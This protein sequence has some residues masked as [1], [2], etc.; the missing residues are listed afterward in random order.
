MSRRK[1]ASEHT[2]TDDHH[3]VRG[4]DVGKN[5]SQ[6]AGIVT[7]GAWLLIGATAVW[8][9]LA[10]VGWTQHSRWPSAAIPFVLNRVLVVHLLGVLPVSCWIGWQVSRIFS[11]GSTK[12]ISFACVATG[13]ALLGACCLA[14]GPTP[15]AHQDINGNNISSGGPWNAHAIR[16]GWTAALLLPWCT[17]A[18]ISARK[19]GVV[20]RQS[21]MDGA[22]SVLLLMVPVIH[23]QEVTRRQSQVV[24]D[25]FVNQQLAH[26][27]HHCQQLVEMGQH[28][29]GTESA[30]NVLLGLQQQVALHQQ[31]VS[32][33]LAAAATFEQHLDRA[34]TLFALGRLAETRSLLSGFVKSEPEAA[35]QIA[36]VDEVDR[37]WQSAA[38]GYRQVLQMVTAE[39]DANGA[40]LTGRP[41]QLLRIATERRANNLRRINDSRRAERE[42]LESLEA[43][44]E[45]E[46]SL[47]MQLGFHYQMAGRTAESVAYFDRAVEKEPRL[48]DQVDAVRSQ[49]QEQAQGCLIRINRGVTR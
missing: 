6:R 39:R 2:G 47:L 43:W 22:I 7:A 37:D 23:V 15:S 31:K 8:A 36:L 29:I 46:A 40:P 49:L 21:W 48:A 26:A 35:M 45:A 11:A 14:A 44:P 38:D 16:L 17:A 41:L 3:S 33:P 10:A 19:G 18:A 4:T 30:S 27:R 20:F 9:T 25:Q 5:S 42:L 32:V 34:R 28:Q 12:T 1:R 13:I 24:A